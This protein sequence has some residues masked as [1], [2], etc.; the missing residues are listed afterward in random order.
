MGE[1]AV[2]QESRWIRAAKW[3]VANRRKIAGALVLALPL[4]A[5]YAP[6]FPA[7]EIMSALRAYLGAA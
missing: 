4:I 5:R 7:D 2:A 1:H 6:G 3:A